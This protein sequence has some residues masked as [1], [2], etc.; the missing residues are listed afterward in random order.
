LGYFMNPLLS[1]LL[2]I[3][4]LR[5]RLRPLQ[6]VP[7][8]L[9]A[10]GVAYLTFVYGRLP[11]IALVLAF[12]FG[13]YGLVKKLAP[14]GSLHGLT[15]ETGILFLPAVLFLGYSE[16]SGSGAFLHTDLRTDLLLIGAG[17]V[18]TIPLLLFASAARRLPLTMV[19]TLQYSAPAMQFLIGV[20]MYKEPFD[21]AH[22]IGFSMVWMALMIF[23]TEGY[24]T[25]RA[26]ASGQKRGES[27][28]IG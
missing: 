7:V 17:A 8:A 2:G 12:S 5:E 10:A 1:M 22:L 28:A 9:A 16:V 13:M 4:F 20:L 14:L 18:T 6:W 26:E 15:L 21:R 11:W 25:H 24:L 3:V 23:W 27:L 19:G